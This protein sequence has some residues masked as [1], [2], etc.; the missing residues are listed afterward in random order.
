[1]FLFCLKIIAKNSAILE[2]ATQQ[3]QAVNMDMMGVRDQINLLLKI[4]RSHQDNA[5]QVLSQD[6]IPDVKTLAGEL[7]INLIIPRRCARQA[8]R[9]NVEGTL[10]EYYR[11]TIYVPYI[12]S[13]IQSL[14]SRFDESNQPHYHIFALHPK[15]I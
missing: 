12:D 6:V 2:P 13:M 4:L 3:L 11:T 7:G 1:M 9:P 5:E 10:E 14:E 15:E 8:H